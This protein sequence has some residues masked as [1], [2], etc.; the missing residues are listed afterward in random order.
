VHEE[1]IENQRE[2]MVPGV[3][4][5]CG[6]CGLQAQ[7]FGRS[8]KSVNRAMAYLREHCLRNEDN[9]YTTDQPALVEG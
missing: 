4:A 7:C 2:K 9:F 1:L 8:Q 6:K 5:T 3:V